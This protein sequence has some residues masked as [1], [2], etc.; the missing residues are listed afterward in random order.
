MDDEGHVTGCALVSGSKL[1]VNGEPLLSLDRRVR[2]A[3]LS[4][5]DGRQVL[6]LSEPAAVQACMPGPALVVLPEHAVAKA[7]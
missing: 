7:G 3:A 5:V 1:E 4:V 2:A 6:E